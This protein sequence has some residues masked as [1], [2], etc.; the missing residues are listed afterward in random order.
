MIRRNYKTNGA[1]GKISLINAIYSFYIGNDSQIQHAQRL[2]SEKCGIDVTQFL[3][4]ASQNQ[5]PGMQN[6]Q[7]QQQPWGYPGY[8]AYGQQPPPQQYGQPPQQS[9]G[10]PPQAWAQYGQQYGQQAPQQQMTPQAATAQPQQDYTAAWAAYYQQYY[11]QYGVAASGA[12]T[13]ATQGAPAPAQQPAV[14]NG[15]TYFYLLTFYFKW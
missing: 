10:Q 11:N 5:Q 2:I 14:S 15:K 12:P 8:N 9:Y 4:Q 3:N 7:Q 1:W 13:S 6:Q